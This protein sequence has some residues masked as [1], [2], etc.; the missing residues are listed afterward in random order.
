MTER[1]ASMEKR[2]KSLLILVAEDD[3]DDQLLIRDAIEESKI[4]NQ[5]TLVQDGLELMDYLNHRGKFSDPHT[6]P[7]PGIILL[8]LNMPR[9]DGREALREIKTNSKLRRIPVIVLTTSKAEEDILHTYEYG[10]N[11][12][13]TK[14]S[15]FEGLVSL[16]KTLKNYW[17]ETVQLPR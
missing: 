4:A 15:S 7:K 10:A 3:P 8:D 16:M 6:S 11:S 13:I 17:F 2:N 1:V 14:P 12:Y 5:I 9:K